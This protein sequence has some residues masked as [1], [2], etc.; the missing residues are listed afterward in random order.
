MPVEAML[1]FTPETLQLWLDQRQLAFVPDKVGGLRCG[2]C[3]LP[4]LHGT[5]HLSIWIEELNAGPGIVSTR[6]FP[7][8]RV[9]DGQLNKSAVLL[10]PYMT[11]KE[12]FGFVVGFQ[13]HFD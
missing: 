9:C 5:L 4:V 1:K 2:K 10:L 11:V 7:L 13:I 12:S 3:D 6:S 8:C